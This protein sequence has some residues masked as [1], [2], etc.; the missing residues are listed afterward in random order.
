LENSVSDRGDGGSGA[1]GFTSFLQYFQQTRVL[2][3]LRV[4]QFES[5]QDILARKLFCFWRAFILGARMLVK[6][7]SSESSLP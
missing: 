3:A 6:S 4:G 1:S 2:V 5:Y 7:A